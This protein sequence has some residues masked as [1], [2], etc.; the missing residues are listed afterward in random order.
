MHPYNGHRS[1]NAWQVSLWMN[2][3]E[4]LYSLARTCLARAKDVDEAARCFRVQVGTCYTPDGSRWTQRAVRD[5]LRAM[6]TEP[7]R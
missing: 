2:N 1:Y 7:R 3:D 6:Q 4:Y 5:A